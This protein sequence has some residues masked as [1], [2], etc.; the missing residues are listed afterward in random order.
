ML[1]ETVP[2]WLV[3]SLPELKTI[4]K[5]MCFV[6]VQNSNTNISSL[7]QLHINFWSLTML[8]LSPENH[9]HVVGVPFC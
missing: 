4:P 6:L 7:F 9:R 8:L 2:Y 1:L 3:F 5:H